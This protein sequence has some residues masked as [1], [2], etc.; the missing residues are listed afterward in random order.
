MLEIA[1]WEDQWDQIVVNDL[2]IGNAVDR[3]NGPGESNWQHIWRVQIWT[4]RRLRDE[5]KVK[6]AIMAAKMHDVVVKEQKLADMEERERK[7]QYGE[8]ENEVSKQKDGMIGAHSR[9]HESSYDDL[10]AFS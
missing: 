1:R 5:E 6:N 4:F 8:R 3:Q 2:N 10:K 7:L 9:D